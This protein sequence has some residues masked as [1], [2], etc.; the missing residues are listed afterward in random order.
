MAYKT[1]LEDEDTQNQ[2]AGLAG[3]FISG[4][5]NSSGATQNPAAP[6]QGTGWTN[7]SQYI[8]ANKGAGAGMA[9]AVTKD[10]QTKINELEGDNGAVQSWKKTAEQESKQGVKNDPYSQT[11]KSGSDK[12]VADINQGAFDAWNQLASYT[13]PQNAQKATGYDTLYKDVANTRDKVQNLG[14]MEGQQTALQDTYG[15]RGNY[16]SGMQTLDALVMRGDESGRNAL[17]NFQNA[18]QNFGQGFDQATAAVN[19]AIAQNRQQGAAN[20]QAVQDAIGARA[21]QLTQR[22]ADRKNADYAKLVNALGPQG[23]AHMSQYVT[24]RADYNPYASLTAEEVLTMNALNDM[25]G[26]GNVNTS[27]SAQ[28]YDMNVAEALRSAF[29]IG[30]NTKKG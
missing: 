22:T 8:D 17:Q 18:N 30:N 11:L 28:A 6:A 2:G 26:K 14:T 27:G 25:L 5:A 29:G 4:G 1:G 7:L 12:Q 15:Q 24:D 20:A 21:N 3:N 16:N 23:V 13:G 19:T 10:T 9:D